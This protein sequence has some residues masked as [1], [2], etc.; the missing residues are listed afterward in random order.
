MENGD[1]M[2]IDDQLVT[3]N[4]DLTLVAA[5]GGVILEHVDLKTKCEEQRRL[6]T[7]YYGISQAGDI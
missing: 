6:F 1:F 7:T 2:S 5:M 4:L 3:L